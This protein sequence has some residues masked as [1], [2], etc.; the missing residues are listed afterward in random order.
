MS[1]HAGL[2]AMLERPSDCTTIAVVRG[3]IKLTGFHAIF[4]PK[5][6]WSFQG[7]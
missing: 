1:F 7:L 3:Q 2:V 6:A 5:T 4:S